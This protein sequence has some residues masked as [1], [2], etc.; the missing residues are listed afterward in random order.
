M[1]EVSCAACAAS[2]EYNPDDYI[3][4]CPYCSS[5][6]VI[7][8]EENSKELISGHFIVQNKINRDKIEKTFKN[9]VLSRYHRPDKID[10]EFKIIGGYCI[11]L[12]FWVISVE[13]HTFWSG[14]SAK[15]K[16]YAGQSRDFKGQFLKEEGRFSKRYRWCILA[17]NSPKEHWGIERLHEPPESV[18]VDW[19]GF[20]F[21]ESLGRLKESD[22]ILY[23]TKVPFKFEY[24][25]GE[26]VS[27]IQIK[28]ST[29]ISRAKDQINEY[30]RR[31]SKTKVGTLYEHKTEIEVVGI[32][33]I[34]IPFWIVRYAFMPD[35]F[36]KFFTT[37]RERRFIIQG[38]TEVILEAELPLNNTDKIMTN[39]IICSVLGFI[40][41][42]LSI[43]VHP[44][45]FVLFTMFLIVSLLSAWKIFKKDTSDK[46]IIKGKE[47][48]EPVP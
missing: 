15:S 20:P 32:H 28:E 48:M 8:I 31:I 16:E 7:D 27:G 4:L 35:S 21:D 37:A 5:G 3:H 1:Y 47:N 42:A 22:K 9:W 25:S 14:H 44:L 45:L 24:I 43:F 13:A 11:Y 41:L 30:H 10:K 18:M 36:F 29:A 40:S 2:F 46:E 12:P 26:I 6:F 38:T 34:H 19:D 17:R 23:N 39:L 33:V